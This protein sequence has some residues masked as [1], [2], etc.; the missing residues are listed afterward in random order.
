[1]K[2]RVE[3]TI[4]E[5]GMY[6]MIDSWLLIPVIDRKTTPGQHPRLAG[7]LPPFGSCRTLFGSLLGSVQSLLSIFGPTEEVQFD[8]SIPFAQ[9]IAFCFDVFGQTKNSVAYRLAFSN[10][11]CS[12]LFSS[13]LTW[14]RRSSSLYCRCL[15]VRTRLGFL[16]WDG[17][18]IR[19]AIKYAARCFLF[20]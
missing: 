14:I 11:S 12:I 4:D 5:K 19:M 1:M 8:F 10:S 6:F 7:M 3:N 17:I 18:D 15:R 13:S 16:L 2:R 20:T 9:D